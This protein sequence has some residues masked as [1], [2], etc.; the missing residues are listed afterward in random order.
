MNTIKKLAILATV[1]ARAFN[2]GTGGAGWKID[3]D[4]KIEMKEGN[5]VFINAAGQEMTVQGDTISNLNREARQHR[6]RAEAAETKLTAFK[7]LD[8]AKAR[9][10]LERVGQIDQGQLIAAGKV[11]EVKQQITTAFQQQITE[12]DN[13][14]KGLQGQLDSMHIGGVFSNSDFVR[15]RIALPR[16]VFQ[17]SFGKYFKMVDG[18]VAAFDKAGNPIYSKKHAGEMASPEEALELLVE[19]HPQKDI[20]LKANTGNGSGNQGGG[21]GTGKGR[22]MKRSE[23]DALSPQQQ[24]ANAV[25]MGNGELKIVD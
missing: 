23:Y 1:A 2:N 10:A 9:E 17:D 21:G 22:T 24:H 12:K 14:L 13:A 19:M 4:G 16:D 6:E 8:P 7:D 25:L 11:D 18:K 15:D 20:I 3:G 5:P